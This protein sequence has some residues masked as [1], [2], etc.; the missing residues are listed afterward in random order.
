[1]DGK[2]F[3]YSGADVDIGSSPA[4]F[5]DEPIQHMQFTNFEYSVIA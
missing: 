1:M 5:I 4:L 2:L 3:C